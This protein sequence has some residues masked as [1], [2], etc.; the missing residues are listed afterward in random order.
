[1]ITRFRFK[2]GADP[3]NSLFTL[4]AELSKKLCDTECI[5]FGIG[6]F[7]VMIVTKIVPDQWDQVGT[8]GLSG[9]VLERSDNRSGIV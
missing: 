4:G 8:E 6:A 7:Q 5:T 3:M 2:N 1:M 9:M